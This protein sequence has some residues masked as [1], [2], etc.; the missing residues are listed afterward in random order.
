MKE[1]RLLR[2]DLLH[3]HVVPHSPCSRFQCSHRGVFGDQCCCPL[4][5]KRPFKTSG[6]TDTSRD[7]RRP[8]A[9]SL[10]SAPYGAPPGAA[11]REEDRGRSG[12]RATTRSGRALWASAAARV[13]A[14][15]DQQ[16][17]ITVRRHP[18]SPRGLLSP[19]GRGHEGA[20]WKTTTT[21]CLIK[22]GAP[23]GGP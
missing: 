6:N 5:S 16:T 15:A 21:M 9:S 11:G 22:K 7:T 8:R 3:G 2:A 18:F 17:G 14:G 13:P 10:D 4:L 19:P 12:R 20:P 23:P 1:H